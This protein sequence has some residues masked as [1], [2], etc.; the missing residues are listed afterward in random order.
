MKNKFA[1]NT[2]T[3]IAT[4]LVSMTVSAKEKV[5]YSCN[6]DE[7]MGGSRGSISYD[8][9]GITIRLQSKIKARKPIKIESP[10]DADVNGAYS[11]VLTKVMN[12]KGHVQITNDGL[13]LTLPEKQAQ[14]KVVYKSWLALTFYSDNAYILNQITENTGYG[15]SDAFPTEASIGLAHC[16]RIK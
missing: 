7:K 13:I 15:V 10:Y 1:L 4:V 16:T 6:E 5:L 2:L 11:E 9:S 8:Q 3:L 12:I 14:L